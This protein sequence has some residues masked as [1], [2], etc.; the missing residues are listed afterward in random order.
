M[1]VVKLENINKS[2]KKKKVLHN[3]SLSIAEKDIFGLLGANGAGKTTLMKIITGLMKPT[4]GDVKIFGEDPWKNWRKLA[5]KVG[6]L[7]DAS[8]PRYLTGSQ[9]LTQLAVLNK[10]SVNDVDEILE[11]VGLT[12]AKHKKVK[13]YSFGMNQRLGLAQAL[14]TKPKLLILDEPFVGVDPK[15]VVELNEKLKALQKEG[16]TF[17]I[18][19]H[20]LAELEQICNKI[21]FLENGY[22]Q[23]TANI[24]EVTNLVGYKLKTNNNPEALKLL[25]QKLQI[26]SQLDGDTIIIHTDGSTLPI[27]LRELT[28]YE[29]QVYHVEEIKNKLENLFIKKAGI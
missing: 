19:S 6:Y 21:A 28:L 12:N 1:E 20:Q 14:L 10:L 24:E 18:S 5:G 23:L 4:S 29:I 7:L 2:F 15:G 26:H 3:L 25:Q 13:E 22:L 8:F 17:I 11:F 9:V 27:V 16:I